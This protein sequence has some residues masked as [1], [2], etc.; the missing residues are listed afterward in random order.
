LDFTG[1]SAMELRFDVSHRNYNATYVEQLIVEVSTDCGANWS[2]VYDKSGTSLATAGAS[3]S[4]FTPTLASQWRNETVSLG[5][6]A[7]NQDVLI[8][9]KMVNGYGNNLYLDNINVVSN[10]VG[11]KQNDVFTSVNIYPNPASEITNIAVNSVISEE[12]SISIYNTIGQLISSQKAK[13]TQ[14]E[15]KIELNTADFA[16]GIYNIEFQSKSGKLVQKLTVSH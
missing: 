9:F 3:T 14:G 15:N 7:G 13:F 2:T 6:Y 1:L 5:S 12:V 8:A 4:A 16:N 11:I 10:P